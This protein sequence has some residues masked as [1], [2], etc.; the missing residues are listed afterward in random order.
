M[1]NTSHTSTD[2]AAIRFDLSGNPIPPQLSQTLPTHLGLH[3]HAEG[4]HA[5]YTLDDIFLLVRSTVPAQ[6]NAM[7]GILLGIAHFLHKDK[8][9][10]S[11]L[12]NLYAKA[13]TILKQILFA[14][15]EVLGE[16]GSV[17]ARAVQVIWECLVK[18][19]VDQATI[20]FR[21]G[22]SAVPKT[23]L[24]ADP[25]ISELDLNLIL[26]QINKVL[27]SPPDSDQGVQTQT[28]RLLLSL[29]H[30]LARY[31]NSI[32]EIIVQTSRMVGN[33]VDVFLFSSSEPDPKALDFLLT[34][35]SASRINAK[36]LVDM[37]IPN[38]LLRFLV[39]AGDT[40]RHSLSVLEKT[41]R[42]YVTLGRYGMGTYVTNDAGEVWRRM[43]ILVSQLVS[44]SPDILK[45][46]I[47]ETWT[48]LLEIWIIC[49]TDPHCTTPDH[50]I[51]WSQVSAWGWGEDLTGLVFALRNNDAL[52]SSPAVDV[53]PMF[54]ALW[55]AITAW[56]EGSRIN[57]VKSGEKER[58]EWLQILSPGFNS[59]L[60]E[61]IIVASV[62][63]LMQN[64][65]TSDMGQAALYAHALTSVVRLWLSCIPNGPLSS[66]P[67]TLPFSKI[68]ELC[69]HLVTHTVWTLVGQNDSLKVLSRPLCSALYHYLKLSKRL[70]DVSQDL[71]MAQAFSIVIRLQQGD[72]NYASSIVDELV[73]M[74]NSEWARTRQVIVPNEIWDKGGLGVIK[75]FLRD[76]IA[77]RSSATL[78]DEGGESVPVVVI[79]PLIATTQ[80]VSRATT[81]R[82]PEEK[83]GDDR[84]GCYGLPLRRDWTL[85]PLDRLLKLTSA[86]SATAQKEVLVPSPWAASETNVVRATLLF[87]RISTV[88]LGQYDVLKATIAPSREEIVFACMKVFMLEHGFDDGT[89]NGEE[90]FRDG[91]VTSLMERLLYPSTLGA[92]APSSMSGNLEDVAV[93][94]LGPSTPLYQFYTDF[95]ALYDAVSYSHPLF[96]R[97]LLPLTSMSYSID[98]RKHLWS[99]F[100]HIVRNIRTPVEEL[101]TGDVREYLWPVETNPQMIGAYLRALIRHGD[102]LEGFVRFIAVHHVASNI[103]G[104]INTLE[105]AAKLLA[106]VVSQCSP[107]VGR[108]VI[109]YHQDSTGPLS[110]PPRCFEVS[111]ERK[112]KKFESLN[113]C[114]AQNV[115]ARLET[116]FSVD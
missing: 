88:S 85:F 30:Y 92:S 36:A 106:A 14:A 91:I 116:Y 79:S 55:R 28:Q 103:W 33:V 73:W 51:L 34:L 49:A 50:D 15:L 46:S 25:L 10:D 26:P 107:G 47:I 98:Y 78:S 22:G 80:T 93:L 101:I 4:T 99:D 52:R 102:A 18:T 95:V 20:E 61:R 19:E 109:R 72:E 24:G 110:L 53:V 8:D 11:A 59:G 27:T 66:P 39:P 9:K 97:L 82:L 41:L 68:S 64:L 65:R 16:R 58:T 13:P 1:N 3:H 77:G 44:A 105:G 54:S 86:M 17:G 100:G 108:D 71:W 40:D 35:I 37:D 94:Y 29:L 56:L 69:A 48:S 57:G 96:S 12:E 115:L 111:L 83:V 74:I 104:G 63:G 70:P 21:Y 112:A 42:V 62:D 2:S 76:I 114:V 45:L 23:S 75:P 38:A 60:E 31:S 5:G 32:A 81:L 87:A 84:Q 90:V 6:R 113:G 89:S 43:Q 7:L 67:F